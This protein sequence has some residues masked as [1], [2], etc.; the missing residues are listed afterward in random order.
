MAIGRLILREEGGNGKLSF[1]AF[2]F[3][4][5]CDLA[6]ICILLLYKLISFDV[7]STEF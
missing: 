4:T 5:L 3:N 6:M 2:L 7:K 1:C